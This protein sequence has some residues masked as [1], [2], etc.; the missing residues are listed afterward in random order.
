MSRLLTA[1]WVIAQITVFAL[2]GLAL[3]LA[4]AIFPPL[5][6]AVAAVFLFAV[7]G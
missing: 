3:L 4:C 7:W 1:L 5:L 6:F 2:V